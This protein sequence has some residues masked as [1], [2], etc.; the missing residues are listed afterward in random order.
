[1]NSSK[2]KIL[3]ACL[4]ALL[5]LLPAQA[6]FARGG[7]TGGGFRAPSL[8][9]GGS[10][11]SFGSLKPFSGWGSATKPLFKAPSAKSSPALGSSA[12]RFLGIGGSR[13]GVSAQRGLFA[14]AQRNGTLFS[15]KTEATQAFRSRFAKDYGSTFAAEPAARPSYIPSSTIVGGRSVNVVY[16]SALGGYGYLNP[17]LGTWIL[18][19][20]LADASMADNIMYGRGYYW[21]GAPVY[22]SHS[23][24]FLS[25]AF[26]LLVFFVIA[27]AVARAAARRREWRR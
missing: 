19:D 4:A 9:L 8:R 16:N 14:S 22:M 5:A 18:Y 20:A 12:P 7:F 27:S 23:P 17:V 25:L 24:G 15:S 10:S 6:A 3:A 21:G 26:G 13:M 1:M 2:A 11:R